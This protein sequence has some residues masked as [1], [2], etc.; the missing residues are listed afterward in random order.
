MQPLLAHGFVDRVADDIV[1]LEPSEIPV[2][3]YVN[4]AYS[5][6][7]EGF[8]ELLLRTYLPGWDRLRP[9]EKA[10]LVCRWGTAPWPANSVR[11]L[12]RPYGHIQREDMRKWNNDGVSL[13]HWISGLFGNSRPRSWRSE[14]LPRW[15][16]D[17][18]Q[19]LAEIIN[20]ADD[21][22]LVHS[23]LWAYCPWDRHRTEV[24][25]TFLSC[26][27]GS[28]ME[29]LANVGEK[30]S[31]K[32]RLNMLLGVLKSCGVDLEAFGRIEFEI[33]ESEYGATHMATV[34][35]VKVLDWNWKTRRA[36]GHC[37]PPVWRADL[38]SAIYYGPTPEDW[39]IEYD[40]YRNWP[41]VFWKMVENPLQ[42][43]VMPG[44][45]AGD[46]SDDDSD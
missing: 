28:D 16:V 3:V 35:C 22:H 36:I 44:A 15:R 20:V 43:E 24:P 26:F 10:L 21:L 14:H 45:W 4:L 25:M 1:G 5:P 32:A 34:P 40:R 6:P 11:R 29:G 38:I 30:E 31:S 37:W 9:S 23:L 19:L 46:D 27:L 18:Q 33:W 42:A 17:W 13:L 2:F 41:A 12:V 7:I 8:F 39:S